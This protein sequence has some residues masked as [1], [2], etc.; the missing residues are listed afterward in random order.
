[1]NAKWLFFFHK[2]LLN[3][4]DET[5][6]TCYNDFYLCALDTGSITLEPCKVTS[7]I[8]IKKVGFWGLANVE[9]H[10]IV[11]TKWNSVISVTNDWVQEGPNKALSSY[12]PESRGTQLKDSM[13]YCIAIKQGFE[14]SVDLL[15]R[16]RDKSPNIITW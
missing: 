7:S 9:S 13:N 4:L 11:P 12:S 3:W 6:K 16:I 2:L 10:I 1:M 15:R 8:Y 5:E 14:I